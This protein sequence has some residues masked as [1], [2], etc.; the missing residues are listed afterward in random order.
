[1]LDM[2]LDMDMDLEVECYALAV[3]V[4]EETNFCHFGIFFY[5][6]N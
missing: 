2:G 1:M 5:F 4:N 6:F 3:L